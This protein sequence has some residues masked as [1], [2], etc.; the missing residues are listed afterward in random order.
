MAEKNEEVLLKCKLCGNSARAK[1]MR[2]GKGG[3][4]LLC[5]SCSKREESRKYAMRN[6]K[7]L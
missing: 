3:K 7:I 5:A 4:D 2:L 1:E 6:V